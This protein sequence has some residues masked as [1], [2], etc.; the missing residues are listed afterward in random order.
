[1]QLRQRY[2]S[3]EDTRSSKR[4]AKIVRNQK[5]RQTNPVVTSSTSG[6][7]ARASP[8]YVRYEKAINV[9]YIASGVTGQR[10]LRSGVSL[11]SEHSSVVKNKAC[12]KHHPRKPK[13]A[14]NIITKSN[15]GGGRKDQARQ[16][17]NLLRMTVDH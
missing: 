7:S 6:K 9:T 15:A 16:I 1:M 13:P 11:R 2:T 14:R 5:S 4:G 17:G 8:S 12:R 10:S 3:A